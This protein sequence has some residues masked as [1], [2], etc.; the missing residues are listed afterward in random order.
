MED[1]VEMLRDDNLPKLVAKIKSE[2][3]IG[4][5]P[6]RSGLSRWQAVTDLH[7]DSIA[8]GFSEFNSTSFKIQQDISDMSPPVC[9]T[10]A[11]PT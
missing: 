7:D 11:N 4:K 6:V 2:Q 1:L 9:M 3:D 10:A 5:M 8:S